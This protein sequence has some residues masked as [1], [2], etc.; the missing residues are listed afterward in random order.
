VNAL[1]TVLL[2]FHA[3][4]FVLYFM[5]VKYESV[6]RHGRCECDIKFGHKMVE[7]RPIGRK[8]TLSP[9]RVVTAPNWFVSERTSKTMIAK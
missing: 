4:F 9:R 6:V 1:S 2:L 7:Q 3:Q 5:R 8:V